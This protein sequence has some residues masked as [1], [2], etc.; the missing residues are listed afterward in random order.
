[1]RAFQYFERVLE[2]HKYYGILVVGLVDRYRYYIYIMENFASRY[3][4]GLALLADHFIKRAVGLINHFELMKTASSSTL[5][6]SIHYGGPVHEAQQVSHL[7]QIQCR[8]CRYL[9][10]SHGNATLAYA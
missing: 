10:K 6:C 3:L 7:K 1:M 8:D 2:S 4:G 9:R 5:V